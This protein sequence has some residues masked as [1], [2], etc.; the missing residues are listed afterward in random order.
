MNLKNEIIIIIMIVDNKLR[1]LH[2]NFQNRNCILKS[3]Y[4]L[5]ISKN[6]LIV[7]TLGVQ[8]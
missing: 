2:F 8:I 7:F 6:E 4:Y 3:V 5:F 1:I